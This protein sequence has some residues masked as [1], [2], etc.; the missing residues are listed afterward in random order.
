VPAPSRF[1]KG[2]GLDSPI[3]ELRA[4]PKISTGPYPI[5]MLSGVQCCDLHEVESKPGPFQTKGSGTHKL[6]TPR[7]RL[8]PA[9]V[10]D[11]IS[12]AQTIETRIDSFPRFRAGRC[13]AGLSVKC[14][15]VLT[16]WPQKRDFRGLGFLRRSSVRT[17]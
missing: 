5:R 9:R 6:K 15:Y 16:F 13:I 3:L 12:D 11:S 17:G 4:T 14:Q 1:S 10:I 7:Q 2:L 8:T